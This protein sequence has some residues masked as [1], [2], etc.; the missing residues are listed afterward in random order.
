M[1]KINELPPYLRR[2]L[3]QSM[4]PTR[5]L[6]LTLEDLDPYEGS[7]LETVQ[8]W[9]DKV[10]ED[11]VIQAKGSKLCGKGL[12]LVGK[13]GHGKTTLAS[14]VLQ[15]I[16]RKADQKIW[17]QQGS[18]SYS[19]GLFVDYPKLLRIQQ[20]SWKDDGEDAVAVIDNIFGESKNPYSILVMDDLGKEHRT[21]SGWAENTFDA[22]LRARYNSGLPTIV[23]TNVPLK[24]WGDVYGEAMESF[25]HEA[26]F[27]VSVVSKEGDR[28]L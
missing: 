9:M 1:Y 20:R 2:Q 17:H 7:V 14:V 16:I 12:L 28:R 3:T 6:G 18:M 5:F 15:E 22:V 19:P 26:F 13:P 8:S 21:S 25:A 23:T 10:L 24:N 4:L 11:K 27:P